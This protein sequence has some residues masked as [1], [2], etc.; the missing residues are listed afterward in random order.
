MSNFF[1]NLGKI[2]RKASSAVSAACQEVA[3][4]FNEAKGDEPKVEATVEAKPKKGKATKGKA[5]K[6][7][8]TVKA[9]AKGKGNTNCIQ[10]GKDPTWMQIVITKAYTKAKVIFLVF[11]N[12]EE[13]TGVATF[14]LGGQY[15]E[16]QLKKLGALLCYLGQSP[17]E[18][19]ELMVKAINQAPEKRV[20]V[21][22]KA[23]SSD[24]TMANVVRVQAHNHVPSYKGD[25]VEVELDESC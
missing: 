24:Q 21:L 10:F 9:K 14:N 2:V 8:A 11:K 18:T 15:A 25:K 1:N 16:N 20:L 22:V 19:V 5:K 7:K 13:Q 12:E 4:G 3:N 23:W 17:Q 6:G